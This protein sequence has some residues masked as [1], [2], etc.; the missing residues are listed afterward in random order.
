MN[1]LSKLPSGGLYLGMD[2]RGKHCYYNDEDTHVLTIGATRCGKSRCV[3]L[4][5]IGLLAF[6]GESIIATDP[7]AE[8]YLYTYPFLKRMG[9][10]V[11][12]LNFE[13]PRRSHR[14]NF[15]QPV[16][17]AVND[18]ALARAISCARDMV[19]SI[20]INDR[21]ERIWTDGERAILAAGILAVVF[22]NRDKPEYQNMTNVYHF[23]GKMCKPTGKKQRMPLSNYIETLDSGHPALS[24]LDIAE[25]APEKMR[26]SFF[27]SALVSLSLFTDPDIYDMTRQTDFDIH[28]TGRGKRA[29]FIILPD[30]KD[31]Y[32][33]V[34]SLFI[35]QHYQTLVEDSR[36]NGNRLPVRVNF[37]CDEFGNFVKIPNYDK[38]ETV[39][40]GRG[41][42]FNLFVQDFNQIDET[43]G[44]KVGKTIRSNC[45][46]WVYMQSDDDDTLNA[47][48]EKLGSYTVKSPSL[49]GSTGGN[50]SASYSLTGRKLLTKDE[51]H[52]IN[53]PYMLVT[54][55]NAPT[56]M[57]APDL[58]ETVFN[59]LFGLGDKLYNQQLIQRRYAAQP[60]R[61][62]LS[63]YDIRL[64]GIWEYYKKLIIAAD[65]AMSI[66][67]N[68]TVQ[69][70]E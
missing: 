60:E 15:L 58:S 47:I 63:T 25:I 2:K 43:Y 54:S 14:Y 36:K 67:N 17:D 52:K 8:L 40:G 16:I 3:V 5:S 4:P 13:N 61:S 28:G 65:A 1:T 24:V 55:R 33:G 66:K 53:R 19:A 39:G 30:E 31:T 27:T 45:E 21:T 18:D 70:I 11:I 9:Y 57:Y 34:A 59:Q 6:S 42:R 10:E 32:Y 41:I 49:S 7:K 64:W 46:T 48:S 68:I 44:D 62:A 50:T 23:I 12:T 51:L 37:I 20:V 29:L 22:D 35:Y 69:E 38:M 26:G 56:I